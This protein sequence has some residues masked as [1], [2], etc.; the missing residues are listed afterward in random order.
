[1]IDASQN[2]VVAAFLRSDQTESL[3][4]RVES[5]P[6]A[7]AVPTGDRLPESEHA[8]LFVRGVTMVGR[9]GCRPGQLLE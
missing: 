2:E 1:M 8:L 3:R 6:V 9:V 5:D 4:S 7:L